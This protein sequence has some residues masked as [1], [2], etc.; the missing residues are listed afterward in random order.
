MQQ[1]QQMQQVQAQQVQLQMHMGE[2]SMQLAQMW[3]RQTREGTHPSW[4]G[5]PRPWRWGA[6]L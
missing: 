1:S 6:K 2:A 3:A 4:Y 5:T